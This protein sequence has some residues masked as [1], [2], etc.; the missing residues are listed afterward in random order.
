MTPKQVLNLTEDQA[1][2]YIE[3]LRWPNGPVCPHCQ[4]TKAYK[5]KGAATRP[6]VHKCA[7]CRKQSTV[8]VGTIFH[9]SHISLKCWVYAFHVVCSSKKGISAHQLHRTLGI[10]YKSA[11]FLA[12]RIRHALSQYPVS[13][14]IGGADK[15]V[16]ADETYIG[17][18]RRGLGRAY[19]GNKIAVVAL[20][21]RDGKVRSQVQKRVTSDSLKQALVEHVHPET[22][23]VTDDHHGYRKAT[24]GFAGHEMVKHSLG[25]YA[26]GDVNSN[27]A[28]SYFSLLKRGVY[29]TFHH[30]SEQHLHRYSD[31]FEFRWNHRKIQDAERTDAAIRQ[32]GG[33]RL[34]YQ[35]SGTT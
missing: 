6:G 33:K 20:V 18:K 13:T 1:R 34:T 32:V 2:E 9:R 17:G 21:E 26:R 27:T 23:I 19:K 30:V 31:E 7:T 24:N 35:M 14:L 15:T 16:E 4:S 5:L 29:G 10:T 22:R 11:W 28:E 8:T 3:Q 12:H 25:E